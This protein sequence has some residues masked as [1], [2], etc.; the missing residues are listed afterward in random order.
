MPAAN[1]QMTATWRVGHDVGSAGDAGDDASTYAARTAAATNLFN[2]LSIAARSV[3]ALGIR[4]WPLLRSVA[5][6]PTG[7]QEWKEM[8][9]SQLERILA[10][11]PNQGKCNDFSAL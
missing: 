5:S 6:P 3:R 1:G 2:L 7:T 10:E 9:K 4:Y 11:E 8:I